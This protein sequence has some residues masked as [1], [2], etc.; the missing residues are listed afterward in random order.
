MTRGGVVHTLAAPVEERCCYTG[1]NTFG[2]EHEDG[3]V[4]AAPGSATAPRVVSEDEAKALTTI[5]TMERLITRA[6]NLLV[7][8]GRAE[9]DVV[10]AALMLD[11]A[12]GIASTRTC[13]AVKTQA[14]SDSI[15]QAA[16]TGVAQAVARVRAITG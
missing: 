10:A 5:E 14:L 11:E 3:C 15:S 13:T 12:R 16:S 7:R 4:K 8:E 9:S 2:R 6:G 1:W